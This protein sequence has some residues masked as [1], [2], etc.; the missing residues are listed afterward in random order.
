MTREIARGAQRVLCRR[1]GVHVLRHSRATDL[2]QSTKRIK[3]VSV[4]LGHAGV[5]TRARYYV[6]DDFSDAELFNGE[7]L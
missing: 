5:D 1:I 2:Y 4:L 3:A 7:A 6:W